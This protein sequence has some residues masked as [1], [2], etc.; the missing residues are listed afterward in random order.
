MPTY[1]WP[2]VYVEEVPSA[3]KPIAGVGTSTAAFIGV[4]SRHHRRLGSGELRRHARHATGQAYTQAAA[5]TPQAVNSW[6]EFTQNFGDI[7]AGQP[8]PRASRLRVLQQR[9]HPLLG[10]PDRRGRQSTWTR[11]CSSWKAS[12]R[13]PSSPR[14]CRPTPRRPALNTAQEHWSTTARRWRTGSRSWTAR[15]TSRTTTWSSPRTRRGIW[16][17]AANPKGYGAFYFPWILVA[18]PL[19]SARRPGRGAAERPRGRHLRPQ[20]RR[21][22]SAQGARQ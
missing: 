18:D 3:I 20:R 22:R 16:R 12:T 4:S 19:G 14:R 10:H 5:L 11:R 15:A 9:G 2:G 8:V 17:P 21:A 13:S 7:Q 6:T 1:T